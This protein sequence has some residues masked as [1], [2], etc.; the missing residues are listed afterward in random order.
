VHRLLTI[1]LALF[2]PALVLGYV[3]INPPED[4][5]YDLPQ[6]L[7]PEGFFPTT[8][9][10]VRSEAVVPTA[11]LTR[12]VIAGADQTTIDAVRALGYPSVIAATAQVAGV[13]VYHRPGFEG[14]AATIAAALD[15]PMGSVPLTGTITDADDQ[16]DVIVVLG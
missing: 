13:A 12:V 16:G 5:P 15:L 11:A 3:V 10:E 6:T 8:S 1:V 14:E 2:L 9:A 7:V 4:N